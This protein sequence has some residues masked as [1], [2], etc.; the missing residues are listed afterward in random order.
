MAYGS[1]PNPPRLP[2][3]AIGFISARPDRPERVALFHP[4][5]LLSCTFSPDETPERICDAAG[6]RMQELPTGADRRGY[7]AVFRG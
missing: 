3:G 1:H 2:E 7:W 6:L 5:G 4:N